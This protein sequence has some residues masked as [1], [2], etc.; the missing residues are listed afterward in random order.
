DTLTYCPAPGQKLTDAK[1]RVKRTLPP[2]FELDDAWL[3][4][5]YQ[6]AI[7]TNM[8]PFG[9]GICGTCLLHAFQIVAELQTYYPGRPLTEGGYF[10]N[11]RLNDN[12]VRSFRVRYPELTGIVDAIHQRNMAPLYPGET[13]DQISARIAAATAQVM[14]PRFHW[15]LSEVS[16]GE[17]AI[18]GAIRELLRANPG[19]VWIGLI[20][21]QYP[22]GKRVRHAVPILRS[23][24][25][26]IVMPTNTSIDFSR[27]T[28]EASS[29]MEIERVLFYLSRQGRATVTSFATLQLTREIAN[30]LSVV[31]SQRNCTGEGDERRGNGQFPRSFLVSQCLSGRCT[32]Q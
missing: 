12:P 4:R 30:P 19:A 5:L 13:D 3:R 17:N 15:A 23:M 31:M 29:T 25:G 10:F 18:L 22:D 16:Y 7:S 20:T 9:V 8:T 11:T 32:I 14:L 24:R 21:R 27:F 26:L 6:I 28:E 2:N 1:T